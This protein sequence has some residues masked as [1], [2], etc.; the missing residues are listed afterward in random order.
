MI[1]EVREMNKMYIQMTDFHGGAIV[2]RHNKVGCMVE[3]WERLQKGN[4][5][6]CGCYVMHLWDGTRLLKV[7]ENIYITEPNGAN[8]LVYWR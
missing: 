3:A 6:E 5:C 2:S 8:P 1:V 7:D 4:T